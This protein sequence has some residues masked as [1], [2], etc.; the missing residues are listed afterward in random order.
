MV[1]VVGGSHSG[2]GKTAL[3]CDLI[4]G[5]DGVCAVKC[6]VSDHH[7]GVQIIVSK[8]TLQEKGKDTRRFFDA[9]AKRVI[10]VQARREE[11]GKIALM[12]G[13]TLQRMVKRCR[14]IIVEGNSITQYIRPDLVIYLYDKKAGERTEG[15]I[16]TERM[17]DITLQAFNYDIQAVMEEIERF[18]NHTYRDVT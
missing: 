5:L 11:L 1:I 10:M 3:I 16:I 15:S 7:N 8:N 18:E 13:R 14:N 2:I 4:E 12:L 6:S 17:A 9:G